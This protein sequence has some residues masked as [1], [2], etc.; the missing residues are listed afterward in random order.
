MFFRTSLVTI[1]NLKQA[2]LVI[3]YT[4]KRPSEGGRANENDT[5]NLTNRA[6]FPN[7]CLCLALKNICPAEKR[8]NNLSKN[9]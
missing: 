7:G 2:P 5:S 9:G 6:I 8:K 1:N 4:E 3:A